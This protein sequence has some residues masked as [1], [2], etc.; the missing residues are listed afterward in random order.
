MN[1]LEIG[2]LQ[3]GDNI[4]FF[5]VVLE[6]EIKKAAN[7]PYLQIKLSDGKK[8]IIAK[9]WK[10]PH[11][12]VPAIGKVVAVRGTVGSFNGSLDISMVQWMPAANPD[13]IED[14]VRVSE[15]NPEQLFNNLSAAAAR[16][17]DPALSM[18]V[19]TSLGNNKVGWL[20]APAAKSNHHNYVGGLLEHTDEVLNFALGISRRTDNADLIIAGAIMHDFG[21]LW[22]YDYEGLAIVMTNRGKLE[23]HI[24]IGIYEFAKI[25]KEIGPDLL[26]GRYDL[27]LQL[28]HIILS[29]H[30]RLEWGS[31]VVPKTPEAQII[32]EADMLSSRLNTFDEAIDGQEGGW[33]NKVYALGNIEVYCGSK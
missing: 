26:Q 10:Y 21:K 14:F 7:G 33:T 32:H 24:A 2:E 3:K 9:Y 12:E 8:D 13:A 23:E 27:V 18:I 16:I 28:R 4:E 1:K 15:T 31:P 17:N 25:V 19:R 20:K 11:T 6:A 5:A 30:G 29:H 22:T